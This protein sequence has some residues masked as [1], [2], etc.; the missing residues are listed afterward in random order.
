MKTTAY[1]DSVARLNHPEVMP[2][3][4]ERVRLSP[5]RTTIQSNGRIRHWGVIP[6]FGNRILRVVV[7]PDGET[8]HNAFFDWGARL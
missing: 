1:F 2:E 3:W 5:V 7:E 4:A 8:I 6:E